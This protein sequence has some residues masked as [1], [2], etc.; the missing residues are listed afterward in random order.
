MNTTRHSLLLSAGLLVA[1]ACGARGDFALDWFSL[2]NGGGTSTGGEYALDAVIGEPVA[3]S[4]SG[5]GYVMDSGFQGALSAAA[6]LILNG[7]FENL[8]N[9]FV[10]DGYGLMPLP[11]GSTNIPGW[12]TT[13]A[14]LAWV[15]NTNTFGAATPFGVFSLE[16]TGYHDARPY[17]GVMQT[18]ATVPGQ[19]YRLSLALGSNADYPGAGGQKSV[20][21]CVD[22]ASTTFTLSPTNASGNL[23]SDFSFTF[24]AGSTSSVVRIGGLVSGGGVYLGLDNVSVTPDSSPP[25]TNSGDLV[26]NGG[27]E[28]T[29]CLFA[30]DAYGLQSLPTGS[31]AIPGW[32]VTNA[33]LLWAINGN[34]FGPG[35]PFGSFFL[36]LTGYHDGLP[37]AGVMQTL[38]TSPGQSYRLSF[39]LGAHQSIAAFSG[40]MSVGV[41]VG[42]VSNVFTF[43]PA[44]GAT[45][46][47]WMTFT[48]DFVATDTATPLSLAGIASGGGGNLG[49]DSVSVLPLT[50]APSELRITAVERLGDD[51]HLSFTSTAGRTYALQSLTDLPLGDW[52]TLPGAVIS[53]ADETLTLTVTNAFTAPRQFYRVQQSP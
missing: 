36:D 6:E 4:M 27:F 2:G 13:A 17:G 8:G 41:T 12:T 21:V 22:S 29:D 32:T 30:P 39:S 51:L 15:S 40:P 5:G 24:T 11:A 38:A 9:T 43:R 14:E 47:V 25:A 31:A 26:V 48:S 42:S 16:L 3:G 35:S 45:G 1:G 10:A 18:I 46:N 44:A 37:Y 52:V 20:S 53:A 23:W 34:A 28:N 7:S 19:Q 50:V 33:E 49:L